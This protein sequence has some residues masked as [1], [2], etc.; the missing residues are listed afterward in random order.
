MSNFF[1]KKKKVYTT[2]TLLKKL[3]VLIRGSKIKKVLQL[4]KK[5]LLQFFGSAKVRY[6]E[7]KS[8]QHHPQLKHKTVSITLQSIQNNCSDDSP[9]EHAN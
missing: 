4:S 6:T 2:Y 9:R 1:T 5:I 8:Q 3:S 7:K